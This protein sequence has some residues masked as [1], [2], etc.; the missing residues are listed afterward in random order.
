MNDIKALKDNTNIPAGL[1]TLL[2]NDLKT[3]KEWGDFDNEYTLENF[4][5]DNTGNGDI[6]ILDGTESVKDLEDGAGLTG[7]LDATIPEVVRLYE[8]DGAIWRI[9]TVVYNDSYSVNFYIQAY[10]GLDSYAV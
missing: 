6:I 1:I 7:G 3:L 10:S 9:I 4:N 2:E 5:T 8:I